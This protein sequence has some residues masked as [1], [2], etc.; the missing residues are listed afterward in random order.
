VRLEGVVRLT[1]I[2]IIADEL[3]P[4]A[5]A[6]FRLKHPGIVL[7]VA[8]DVRSLSLTRREADVALRVGR[9]EQADLAIRRVGSLTTGIYAHPDYLARAGMPDFAAGA[10]GHATILN[11]PEAMALPEMQWFA[12]LTRA[13]GVALRHNSR[14]GQ[15]AAAEAGMGLAVLSRFMGDPTGLV[16]LATPTPAPVRDLFLAVHSDIRHTPRIRAVSDMLAAAMRAAAG[17]LAP[18]VAV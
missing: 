3:L 6:A 10:P 18:G 13:A 15:R 16:R 12:G 8:A 4:P 1:T 14:Y 9:I 2:E 7:E 5:L 17:R 11:P